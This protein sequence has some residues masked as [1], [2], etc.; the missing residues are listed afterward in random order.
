MA[1]RL[2]IRRAAIATGASLVVLLTHV[3]CRGAAAGV[4]GLVPG[5]GARGRTVR[6][7]GDG[8]VNREAAARVR[9]EQARRHADDE[10]LRVAQEVHDVVGHGLAAINMQAEIALH[11]LAEAAG[12]GGDRA[13][14]DQP[15]QPGGARRAAGHAAALAGVRRRTGPRRPGWPGCRRCATGWPT[16]GLPVTADGR[17]AQRRELPAAVDLAGVP[18]GAGVADQRAAPRRYGD[19]GGAVGYRPDAVRSR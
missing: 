15:D 11:L 8:A 3:F 14:R 16:A 2:P 17:R 12:A 7:G 10:R 6:G 18:G 9:A 4:V 19:R 5:G 1:T 13:D